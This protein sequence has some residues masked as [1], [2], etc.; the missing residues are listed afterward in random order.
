MYIQEDVY[1]RSLDCG[2]RHFVKAGAEVQGM[3]RPLLGD[4]AD[5]DKIW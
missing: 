2:S 5:L 1:S 4:G 3:E